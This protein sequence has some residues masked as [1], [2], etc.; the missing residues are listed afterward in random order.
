MKILTKIRKELL[1]FTIL[2]AGIVSS[3]IFLFIVAIQQSEE[4]LKVPVYDYPEWYLKTSVL[5]LCI[6][7]FYIS[8]Y[9]IKKIKGF[10]LK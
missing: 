5:A 6:G 2:N 7:L 10:K 8:N 3:L 4:Y 1:G 9:S